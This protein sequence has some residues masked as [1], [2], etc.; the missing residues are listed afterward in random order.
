MPESE[1][2][3]EVIERAAGGDKELRAEI[4]KIIG[5]LHI[6]LETTIDQGEIDR[7][8]DYCRDQL[9]DVL[10]DAG[11]FEDLLQELNDERVD[12]LL[13]FEVY[14]ARAISSVSEAKCMDH[15]RTIMDV[16]KGSIR[17]K[18][19]SAPIADADILDSLCL[20]VCRKAEEAGIIRKEGSFYFDI[21]K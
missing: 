11:V 6:N 3:Q 5:S 19:G 1:K 20:M 21:K 18:Y 7:M 12:F 17:A 16:M 14:V 15:V 9:E 13:P 10:D 2:I 8:I 4:I